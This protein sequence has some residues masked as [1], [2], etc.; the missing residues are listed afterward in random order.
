MKHPLSR[1]TFLKSSIAGGAALAVPA[2]SYA[3]IVGANDRIAI[4]IIG[5]GDRG[6]NAHMKGVH[7]HAAEQKIEI[8]AVSDPWRVRREMA[9]AV[10]NEWYG[11]PARQFSSYRELVALRDLD[12]VMIASPDHMH[13]THLKAA[14]EAG[15]GIYCEKPLAMDF[16]KLKDA[17]D[18]VKKANVVV[19]IGTQLR[20]LPSFTGCRE[21]YK[22]GV[23]GTVSRIEQCRNAERPYWYSYVKDVKKEDV[24]WKEFLGDRP[25]Q[26]FDPVKYSGWY[27][28]REFSDG[29]VPGLGSHFIDLVHYIT[30]ATFPTSCVCLGGT[31]TYKDEHNFTCPD[32]VQALWIY[33]EGFMVSYS[34]NFGNGSGNSFKIFGD[35]GVLD[36]VTWTAPVLSAEGGAKRRG[37]IRGKVPVEDVPRPDHFLDWLQC[38]RSRKT[39]NASIDAGY[40]HAVACLMAVRSFDTGKRTIYDPQ[41]RDIREG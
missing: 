1:R 9:S 16:G 2:A 13:T 6:I 40:Q 41:K 36:M 20:S 12:A 27:G 29:P 28:Y 33:P 35:E 22:T 31:F 18:A 7:A 25:A 23:L 26:P 37:Q 19:Q 8:T 15:K 32:H 30:G 5:C 4:G 11:R 21:L 10:A 39:P 34:T 14:A 17:C 3:R 24:D 38:L